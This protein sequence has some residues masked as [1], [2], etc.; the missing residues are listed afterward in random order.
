MQFLCIYDKMLIPI[1]EALHLAVDRESR[2]KKEPPMRQ[3]MTRSVHAPKPSAAVIPP[4]TR[5]LREIAEL[6]AL[7][8]DEVNVCVLNRSIDRIGQRTIDFAQQVLAQKDYSRSIVVDAERPDLREL[9]LD[10]EPESGPL[11]SDI[12]CWIQVFADLLGPPRVGVRLCSVREAMCPRFHVDRVMARLILTYHGPGTEWL[13]SCDVDRRHLGLQTSHL[14]DETSGL[15]RH[16]S[17]VQKMQSFSV[18]ILKGEAWPGNL[19]R[20]AVH[21]SPMLAPTQ[22]LSGERRVLLTLDGLE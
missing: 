21:R 7:Y 15:I 18:G 20:G 3:Q 19:G 12:A 16:P 4:S 17:A 1:Q 6:T 22:R 5:H 8:D 11:L 13:D 9:A 14:T 2:S 10:D